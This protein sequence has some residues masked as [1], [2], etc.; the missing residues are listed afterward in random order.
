MKPHLH[1]V[2][3]RATLDVEATRGVA[4]VVALVEYSD[5]F[6]PFGHV[7]LF[8]YQ[9]DALLSLLLPAFLLV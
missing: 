3:R 8:F 9:I 4:F 6:V 2:Q 5:G 1:L 7:L